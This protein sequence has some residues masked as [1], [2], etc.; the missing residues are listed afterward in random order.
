[1][2]TVSNSISHTNTA[3][4]STETTL[5]NIVTSTNNTQV[6]P[7]DASAIDLGEITTEDINDLFLSHM[8][9]MKI[10]KMRQREEQKMKTREAMGYNEDWECETEKNPVKYEISIG[11]VVPLSVTIDSFNGESMSGKTPLQTHMDSAKLEAR[12]VGGIQKLSGR[13]GR[14][15][16]KRMKRLR[17]EN[18]RQDYDRTDTDKVV[19]EGRDGV[20]MFV[21]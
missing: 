14:E 3:N 16:S 6:S 15:N 18:A 7:L 13:Q 1:M 10:V 12:P 19:V 5:E 11:K 8:E 2:K 21:C 20:M 9:K 17:Q 4:K